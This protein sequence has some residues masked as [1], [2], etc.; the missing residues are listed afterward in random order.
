M[1]FVDPP[2]VFVLMEWC[3]FKMLA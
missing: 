1:G 3:G 2:R